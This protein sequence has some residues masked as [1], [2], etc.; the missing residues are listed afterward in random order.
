MSLEPVAAEKN[1]ALP[2]GDSVQ[3]AGDKM[4]SLDTKTWPVTGKRNLIDM[5]KEGDP[6]VNLMGRE[7]EP[8]SWRVGEIVERHAHFY[9]EHQ[10]CLAARR[11]MEELDL[12]HLPIVDR[13]MRIV[14]VLSRDEI[15][16]SL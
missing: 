8:T 5:V 2:V 11:L 15:D 6:D 16:K 3:S 10:G 4:R 13:D 14:S 12:E 9:Y 7:R 1:G